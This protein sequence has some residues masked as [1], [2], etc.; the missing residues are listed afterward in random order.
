MSTRCNILLRTPQGAA[1][2]F[3]RH[4][5]GYPSAAGRALDTLY[6]AHIVDSAPGA[7]G[8]SWIGDF[9]E[10]MVLARDDTGSVIWRLTA[11]PH[12]DI[13]YCYIFDFP[14]FEDDDARAEDYAKNR[15]LLKVRWA[16]GGYGKDTVARAEAQRPLTI[17]EFRRSVYRAN[18]D[19]AHGSDGPS[20]AAVVTE[21]A[22]PDVSL[23]PLENQ[24][25][26]ESS[27]TVK[28]TE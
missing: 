6:T 13:E 17:D 5:D 12:Q 20:T 14:G 26:E 27:P 28:E 24:A 1:I 19:E 8:F 22:F 18:A 16:G 11:G 23:Q 4:G 2:W 9:A 25:S 7:R 3:Y 10:R 21:N 15:D